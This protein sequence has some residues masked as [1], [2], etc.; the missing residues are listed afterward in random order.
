VLRAAARVFAAATPKVD[1]AAIV[2]AIP[3]ADRAGPAAKLR[4]VP[5]SR[6][7][8]MPREYLAAAASLLLVGV[9]SLAVV[10]GYFVDERSGG[11][12]IDLGVVAGSSTVPVDLVGGTE[13][14]GLG[15]DELT[16]LLA[17]LESM[18]ATIAAEPITM[19]QPLVATPEGL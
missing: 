11:G 10:R 17:E 13:L 8:W 12:A 6:G 14:A 5:R 1:T 2:R 18:E 19:R 4:L 16:A 9:L 7:R 3:T 15:A